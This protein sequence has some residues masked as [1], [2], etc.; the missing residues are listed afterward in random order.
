VYFP[1]SVL[2]QDGAASLAATKKRRKKFEFEF[3]PP[4]PEKQHTNRSAHHDN[5][6]PIID[7]EAGKNISM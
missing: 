3:P 5:A 1:V 7:P 4:N 6:E 2:P